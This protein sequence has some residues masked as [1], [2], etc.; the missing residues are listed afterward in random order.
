MI[1]FI[2]SKFSKILK[3]GI[4][5]ENL[6]NLYECD[7]GVTYNHIIDL[8]KFHEIIEHDE[9]FQGD[10]ENRDPH[11]LVHEKAI[12]FRRYPILLDGFKAHRLAQV[13]HS[14]LFHIANTNSLFIF[15]KWFDKLKYEEEIKDTTSNEYIPLVIPDYYG[16]KPNFVKIQMDLNNIA[17]PFKSQLQQIKN[18]KGNK[19][20]VLMGCMAK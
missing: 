1:N 4:C 3:N 10:L 15:F 16:G 8:W 13:D 7:N 14:L 17:G 11:G 5:Y 2:M 9:E 18:I 19:G 6:I 20:W 12:I